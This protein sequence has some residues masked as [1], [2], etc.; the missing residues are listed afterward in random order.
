VNEAR[1]KKDST[2]SIDK[3]ND[4]GFAPL[5]EAAQ[6]DRTDVAKSLLN[7][8]ADIDVRTREVQK[9]IGTMVVIEVKCSNGHRRIW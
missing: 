3:L 1:G 4:A 6:Y 8:G 9:V 5:H 7:R 2:K